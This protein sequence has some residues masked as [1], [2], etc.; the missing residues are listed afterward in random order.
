M[1]SVAG[2][3]VRGIYN[4]INATEYWSFWSITRQHSYLRQKYHKLYV[5]VPNLSQNLHLRLYFR[6]SELKSL[7]Q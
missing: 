7:V 6:Q 5:C 3:D 1:T 2:P 4:R